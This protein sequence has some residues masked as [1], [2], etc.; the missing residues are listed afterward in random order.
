MLCTAI[1]GLSHL[2]V[3]MTSILFFIHRIICHQMFIRRKKNAE[4][5]YTTL[6]LLNEYHIACSGYDRM[7]K[8][9][10][11]PRLISLAMTNSAFF[12]L[13]ARLN[14]YFATK[15]FCQFHLFLVRDGNVQKFVRVKWKI[16]HS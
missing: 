9:D 15:Y 10:F 14:L 5:T 1:C 8:L 13:S 6:I 7:F 12:F 11:L 3:K 4:K 2:I 16:F